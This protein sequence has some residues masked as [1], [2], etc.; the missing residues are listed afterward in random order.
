MLTFITVFGLVI[1]ACIFAAMAAAPH[2]KP[3]SLM[4]A[5]EAERDATAS[6]RDETQRCAEIIAERVQR[7][8][9]RQ[10]IARHAAELDRADRSGPI[11]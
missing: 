11:R 9:R 1:G 7:E 6:D 2:T 8:A 5:E 3:R 10:R 4:D